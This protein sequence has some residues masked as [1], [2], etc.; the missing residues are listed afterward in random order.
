MGLFGGGKKPCP[1][2]GTP[3]GRFLMTKVEGQAL[4][5]DCGYKASKLPSGMSAKSMSLD[6]VR[7]FL[8]FYDENAALRDT[9]QESYEFDF[10]F[11]GG[12]IILDVPNRLI[13]FSKAADDVVFEAS[14]IKS[15][16][17]SEDQTPLFKGAGDA[18][19]CHQSTVP[20]RVQ[21]LGPEINRYL[22]ERRQ[23]EQMERMEEMLKKQAKEAGESYSPSYYS[24]PDVDLLK[25]FGKFWLRI[26]LEHPYW[27]EEEF[28]WGGP[29]FSSIDP[30][31][32][33]YLREYEE[34][35]ASLRELADQLMAVLNP[36]ATERRA[37]DQ[38]APGIRLLP[39]VPSAPAAPQVDAV[40]E[41]QRYKGLL[42]SGIITEE[43]F[44]AK[45]RQLLGI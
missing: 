29:G 15:F 5:S 34:K 44:A 20:E 21:G 31:I 41:I 28:S 30:S 26:E 32:T 4:C 7:G 19:T 43:E 18:L 45:K 16:C 12:Y 11:L 13:R 35:V 9:F 2:C 40:E 27:S 14:N 23:Y 10:G 36:D 25:P 24:S 22:M 38:E 1:I 39:T 33:A 37:D 6:E 8:S 42:D 17:I 3:T